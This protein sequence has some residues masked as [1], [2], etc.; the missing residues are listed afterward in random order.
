MK[1]S[2]KRGIR[3]T[4]YYWKRNLFFAVAFAMIFVVLAVLA[5]VQGNVDLAIKETG[6][7]VEARL[8]VRV[9][10]AAAFSYDQSIYYSE[11]KM[12]PLE[13]WESVKELDY[14]ALANARGDG[15]EEVFSESQQMF[16][17]AAEEKGVDY[18]DSEEQKI[19]GEMTV[20]GSNDLENTWNFGKRETKITDGQGIMPENSSDAVAVVSERFLKWNMLSIGDEI[21][22]LN[23]FDDSCRISVRVAGTHS[24]NYDSGSVADSPMNFIYVPLKQCL[25]LNGGKVVQTMVTV[26]DP[27]NIRQISEKLQNYLGD[28]FEIQEDSRMYLTAVTPLRGVQKVCR[29]MFYIMYGILLLILFLVIGR[30]LLNIRKEIG[31]W[32]SLGEIRSA[33]L[34]QSGLGILLP[35]FAGMIAGNILSF[36]LEQQFGMALAKILSSFPDIWFEISRTAIWR[37]YGMTFVTAIIM[38]SIMFHLIVRKKVTELLGEE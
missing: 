30:M 22:L 21:T 28:G 25:L 5:S 9:K 13:E 1:R 14:I 31:I 4:L 2:V 26:D 20:V 12:K 11:S 35:V 10:D 8:T 16:K 7:S 33:L 3:N 36:S 38:F 34:V 32:I 37:M 24:D 29:I 17:E 18:Y 6:K 15:V 19:A 27:E 23:A